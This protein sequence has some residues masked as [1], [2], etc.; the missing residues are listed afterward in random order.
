MLVWAIIV[1]ILFPEFCLVSFHSFALHLP[2]D[3]VVFWG[4]PTHAGN[5][6]LQAKNFEGAV[7]SYSQAIKLDSTNAVYFSNR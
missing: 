1:L 6:A 4:A 7:A 5:E 3:V 2:V